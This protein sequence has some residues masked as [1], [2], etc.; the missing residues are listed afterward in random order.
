MNID[1][2]KIAEKAADIKKQRIYQK[3]VE[4]YE[5]IDYICD[6]IEDYIKT[7]ED[8]LWNTIYDF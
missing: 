7:G 1:E 8:F 5:Q 4:A 2:S 3:C 6:V